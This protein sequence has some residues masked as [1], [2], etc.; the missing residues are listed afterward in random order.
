MTCT[1]ARMVTVTI[2]SMDPGKPPREA[3]LAT[4]N[5]TRN[6]TGADLLVARICNAIVLVPD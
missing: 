3:I 5:R 2:A 1:I 6:R 4:G